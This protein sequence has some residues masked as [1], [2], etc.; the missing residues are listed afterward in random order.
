MSTG[1]FPFRESMA[2][3]ENNQ[4]VRDVSSVLERTAFSCLQT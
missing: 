2:A 3:V 1:A 4:T